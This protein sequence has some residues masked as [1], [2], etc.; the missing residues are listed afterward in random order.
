MRRAASDGAW[1]YAKTPHT[2]CTK[3]ENLAASQ[4]LKD[5]HSPTRPRA[6]TADDGDDPT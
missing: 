2:Q 5:A 6:E 4:E 3:I 1:T